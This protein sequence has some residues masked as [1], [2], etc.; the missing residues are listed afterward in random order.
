M[1]ELLG[2]GEGCF[3]LRIE[4]VDCRCVARVSAYFVVPDEMGCCAPKDLGRLFGLAEPEE[5]RTEPENIPLPGWRVSVEL[6]LDFMGEPLD[7]RATVAPEWIAEELGTISLV[8][9]EAKVLGAA[10]SLAWALADVR[11]QARESPTGW[12]L[13]AA[14]GE[15]AE[16][17]GLIVSGAPSRLAKGL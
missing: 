1:T 3:V 9:D 5:E 10:K 6:G 16:L 2:A 17:G 12:A 13:S 14:R 11:E 7:A 15:R 8:S 4:G